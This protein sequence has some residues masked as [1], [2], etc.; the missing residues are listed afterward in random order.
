MISRT[1]ENKIV[2]KLDSGKAIIILGARQT[3]KTTLLK[4]MFNKEDV[5]W[6]DGDEADVRELFENASSTSLKA[7]FAKYNT[8]VIDEAQRINEIGLRLKLITDNIKDKKLIVSGSSAFELT[9]K[10]NEPLTGRKWEFNLFPLSFSE[11]V[12][13]HGLMEEK[14]LLQHRLI[15]GYYPEVVNGIGYEKEILKQLSESYLY[16]DI[17]MWQN[18]K[19]PEK[20]V[21]LIQAL[22]LQ[23]GNEVSY[24]ELGKIVGLDNETVAK[25]IDLLEKSFV[26]FRLHAF[27]RNHRKEL[28]QSRKVYFY[29]NGIRNS[30][31]SNFNLPGLRQDLGALWE[32]FIISERMKFTHYNGIWTNKYFWRTHDQQE[33]DYIEENDGILNA[34]EIK[35]NPKKKS[36]LSATFARL[37][38]NHHFQIINNDNFAEFIT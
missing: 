37:Y 5:L 24:N 18:L 17:L 10:L 38:P 25:Y 33:I 34:F 23:L 16:K 27:S 21:K 31:I 15:Y 13:H 6:L 3:G 26:V 12:E 32:N 1:L 20:L 4:K 28:K 2:G 7:Y 22:A 29:D 14:R 30:I 8:I 35:W 19:R 9:N 36:S 11:M